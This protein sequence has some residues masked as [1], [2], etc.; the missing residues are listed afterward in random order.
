M[1]SSKNLTTD[2]EK[3]F[4]PLMRQAYGFAYRLTYNEQNAKDLV[5]ETY[6]KAFR[7]YESFQKGT[8]AKAWLF[9][10]LKNTF[11]NDYRKKIK[12]PYKYD[13]NEL[14]E[15]YNAEDANV[16]I[17]HS[18][19]SLQSNKLTIEQVNSL[20]GDEMTM[21]LNS[22]QEDFRQIIILCDLEDL[23]YEEIADILE[24]PIGTVRSRLHRARL[25][26]KD[27]IKDY[28]K[29]MGYSEN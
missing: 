10:I 6:I 19:V 2:F 13:Y 9:R 17:D 20:M 21:A 1:V 7:F 15:R 25:A 23:K 4:M 24:I 26:L 14:E 29:T 5:Q 28:A 8:N 11:I 12:E 3:E 27:K 22:L 18:L 16:G